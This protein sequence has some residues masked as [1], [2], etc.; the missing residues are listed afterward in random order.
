MWAWDH[1]SIWAFFFQVHIPFTTKLPQHSSTI[2]KVFEHTNVQLHDRLRLQGYRHIIIQVCVYMY[3]YQ[4]NEY[5]C[6]WTWSM[7]SSK[8]VSMGS[9]KHVS[10]EHVILKASENGNMWSSRHVSMGAYDHPSMCAI[11][12]KT[13]DHASILA[14]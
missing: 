10:M 5:Q 6:M 11:S 4:T 13:C 1:V 12:I 8:H 3:G 14:S 2:L 7:R 9:S